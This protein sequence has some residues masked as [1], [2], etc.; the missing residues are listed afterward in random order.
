VKE[1]SLNNVQLCSER[2][3]RILADALPALREGGFLLYS[4]CSY[5]AEEDEQIMDWI[6]GHGDL[7]PLN[8]DPDPEWGIVEV[9]AEAGGVGYRFFPDKVKGEGF[10]LACF[11]KGE[12]M[13]SGDMNY[14]KA[15]A[16]ASFEKAI[17]GW[18]DLSQ[19]IAITEKGQELFLLPSAIEPRVRELEKLLSLRK[20]G[21]RAGTIIRDS[22]IPDHELVLSP[23]LSADAPSIDLDRSEALKYLRKQDIRPDAEQKGWYV[24]RYEGLALGLI[25]HLGN[26][27]NNYYPASWRILMS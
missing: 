12:G 21:V 14:G 25:K 18:V 19:D 9:Q 5:S 24:I 27:V 22:F 26:R 15:R 23:Y 16:T 6:M 10:F 13:P 2:Q 8:L 3:K 4:T 17:K 1:W 11:R 20:T 7:H